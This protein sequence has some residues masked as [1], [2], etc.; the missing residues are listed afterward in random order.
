[1]VVRHDTQSLLL[2]VVVAF[3][4]LTIQ[5]YILCVIFHLDLELAFHLCPNI[6]IM[7]YLHGVC[8]KVCPDIT[9]TVDWA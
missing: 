8:L 4:M 2:F 1:M 7:I 3:F 9:V 5:L 6:G